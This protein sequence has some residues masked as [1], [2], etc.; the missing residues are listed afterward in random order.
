MLGAGDKCITCH[1]DVEERLV[2]GERIELAQLLGGRQRCVV[3]VAWRACDE[4]L[5]HVM[6]GAS[7]QHGYDR[8][9]EG[10]FTTMLLFGERL[11]CIAQKQE[12]KALD[13]SCLLK[14]I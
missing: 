2:A 9:L 11:Q 13:T 5:L 4:I 14:H 8:C 6:D 12:I 1:S 7:P 10:W 3:V